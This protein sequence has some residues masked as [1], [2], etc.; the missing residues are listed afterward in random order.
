MEAQHTV[1]ALFKDAE[2]ELICS[3]LLTGIPNIMRMVTGCD[4]TSCLDNMR[5]VGIR[6]CL[7]I[8]SARLYPEERPEVVM[9]MRQMFPQME[10]LLV[11]S[12]TDP[13]P[14]LQPLVADRVRHLAINPASGSGEAGTDR[15]QFVKAVAKL[16]ARRP[17][18]MHD[19]LPSGVAVQ[20]HV[21]FSSADKEGLISKVEAAIHGEGD[22]LEMLRQRAA[23]L[24]DEMLE[25]AMYG[26]PRGANG[27]SLYRK[28]EQR[29]V[30]EGERIV[31][32]FAFDGE[33]LAMEIA[34]SW[35]SL[36][37]ETVLEHLGKNL[38]GA[39]FGDNHGGRGLFIIWRFLDHLHITISPGRQTV[40]G[41]QLKASSPLDPEQPKGFHISTHY[42]NVSA[43]GQPRQ[44]EGVF[45]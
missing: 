1:L 14:H 38:A 2:D 19:Y 23:L 25:N 6:P 4:F 16:V 27:A 18:E 44:R 8:L 39:D 22:E 30:H 15:V 41:G 11:S 45:Q 35:G 5:R 13:F 40:V 24:A 31:F 26:A 12:A 42:D 7:T 43:Q 17:W 20:E 3:P 10:F 33:T 29:T 37:A 28:G 21:V 36:S 9:H 32:R 34:D